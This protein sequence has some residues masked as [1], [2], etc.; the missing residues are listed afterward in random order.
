MTNVGQ[1]LRERAAAVQQRDGHT[2]CQEVAATIERCL[3]AADAETDG[4]VRYSYEAGTGP[5]AHWMTERAP[6]IHRIEWTATHPPRCLWVK[7]DEPTCTIQWAW[8]QDH[9]LRGEWQAVDAFD[10][11]EG[12]LDR[13]VLALAEQ[14]TWARGDLP[15]VR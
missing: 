1:E 4:A 8:A 5:G 15:S 6:G 3:K 2:R 14:E 11:E 9:Q 10:F 12:F 13:L 7:V